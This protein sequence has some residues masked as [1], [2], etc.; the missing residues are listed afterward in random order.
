[1]AKQTE[2]KKQHYNKS[3]MSPQSLLDKLKQRGLVIPDENAALNALKF[4]GY[5]RLRGYCYPF[6]QMTQERKPLPVLP[7]TFIEGTTFDDIVSLYEF[8]RRVRLLIIEEIQK[9]EV[10]LRTCISEHMANSHGPHWFMN[11]AV[12]SPTF[13]Y[14]GFH[15][16]IKDAKELFISHYYDNYQSPSLPPSWM[17]TEVLTFGTWS[18][19]YADLFLSDQKAIA[20]QFDV[21]S[22]EVMGSWFHCLS[23]LRNL[24]AH[25]NRVWNRSFQVFM[26]RDTKELKEHM[27]RKNTLY[28]RLCVIKHLSDQVSVSNGLTERL[29]SLLESAPKVVT[30]EQMGFLEGWQE[31]TLWAPKES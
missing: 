3:T 13:E 12:L 9:V 7:K 2:I 19:L 29:L 25:H 17:I 8:D 30:L 27:T 23:H 6:Y 18:R 24:C 16:R 21:K 20:K 26:P 5:F 31:H 22:G 4:I 28:S 11:L 10:G 15:A 14:D 1:M